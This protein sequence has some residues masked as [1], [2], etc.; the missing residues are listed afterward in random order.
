MTK[1]QLIP[2]EIECAPYLNHRGVFM[3]TING[4]EWRKIHTSIF[5]KYPKLPE[6]TSSLQEFAEAFD[7]LEYQKARNYIVRYLSMQSASSNDFQ[8]LFSER[9]VSQEN[10]DKVI[11]EFQTMGYINDAEWLESFVRSQ[12]ARKTGPKMI[13]YKLRNKGFSEELIEELLER[14]C[15]EE[16]QEDRLRTILQT[17]YKNKDLTDY[18]EKQKVIAALARKGFDFELII[19]IIREL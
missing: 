1:D 7:L 4:E 13:E 16:T 2:V 15:T 9:F 18:N 8:R 3:I 10:A 5:G 11:S 12:L 19:R 14:C 6:K 17:K